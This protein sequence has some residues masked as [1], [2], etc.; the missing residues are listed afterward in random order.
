MSSNSSANLDLGDR[1]KLYEGIE[2]RRFFLPRLPII[3]RLDGRS[4]HAFTRGLK[5]PYDDDFRKCMVETSKYLVDETHCKFAYTQSDEITLGFYYEDY[6]SEPFFGG[7]I[8]KLV[9]VL[10]G[11]ATAKFNQQVG[12]YLP[13]KASLLPVFDARVFNV[14][15]LEEAANCVLFRTLD[16]DKNS[17]HM[18]ASCHFSDAALHKVNTTQKIEML[19]DK[20]GIE[21]ESYYPTPFRNGVFVQRGL[22][23]RHLTDDELSRIPEKHRPIE[24]VL[25][26]VLHEISEPRFLHVTNKVGFLFNNEAPEVG[27]EK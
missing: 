25:R 18:A 27:K 12:L 2:A 9:S 15:T 26:S 5:R 11:L 21:W 24:P 22:V 13:D 3:A 4:F 8:Q 1:M 23:H 14:P 20:K 10:A 16:C 7:R 19:R 6:K 17:V